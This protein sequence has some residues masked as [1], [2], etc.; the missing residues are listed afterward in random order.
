[1][2]NVMI[3][4]MR[5]RYDSLA[6]HKL[7]SSSYLIKNFPFA[8]TADMV[9]EIGMGKGEMITQLAQKY[10]HKFF[11]GL[12]KYP[13]VAA[14]ALSKAL[15]LN[16]K[17]F[18]IINR[19]A[20]DLTT[21]FTGQVDVIWLTFSDPWPKK[22]H[23][24]RRLTHEQ[25]LK[26]YQKLLTKHGLIKLKTDNDDFF[27]WS[28]ASILEFGGKIVYSTRDLHHDSKNVNNIMTEY[29]HKWSNHGKKINYMEIKL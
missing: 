8:L 22:R 15:D 20:K 18:K 24:K 19:D 7:D 14:K 4:D 10:P 26:Q 17:N 9:L 16:L 21:L 23:A 1:M 27:R 11:L 12:E 2:L 3:Y 29:E 25:F 13:T 28:Q 6:I 5:L